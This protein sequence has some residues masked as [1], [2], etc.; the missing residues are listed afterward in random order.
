MQ[1]LCILEHVHHVGPR[2]H[3]ALASTCH[4]QAANGGHAQLAKL[5]GKQHVAKAQAPAQVAPTSAPEAHGVQHLQGG[6][7]AGTRAA[8]TGSREDA[9][10]SIRAE[11]GVAVTGAGAAGSR[12]IIAANS[13]AATVAGDT[14]VAAAG[15]S[16][17]A[18]AE[19]AGAAAAGTSAAAGG[20]KDQLRNTDKTSGNKDR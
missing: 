8:A 12:L 4:A 9:P 18:A 1:L 2:A 6:A 15:S 3:A 7:A 16:G 17:K 19:N 10:A 14:S 20:A 13:K 5:L 11:A